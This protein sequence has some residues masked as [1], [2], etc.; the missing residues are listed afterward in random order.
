[1]FVFEIKHKIIIVNENWSRDKIGLI[2]YLKQS[3]NGRFL[4]DGEKYNERYNS[5]FK[6]R[7][8]RIY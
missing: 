1:M 4:I 5:Y 7:I 6:L 3:S 2:N 8:Q